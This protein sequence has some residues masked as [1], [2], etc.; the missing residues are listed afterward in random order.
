MFH[1]LG[2]MEEGL[3]KTPVVFD[4]EFNPDQLANGLLDS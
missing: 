1:Q 2:G 4:S 3:G